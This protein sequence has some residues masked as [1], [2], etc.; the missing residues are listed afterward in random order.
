MGR[1]TGKSG[2]CVGKGQ[3][4][5]HEFCAMGGP[6]QMFRK[7][8]RIDPCNQMFKTGQ[9][10]GIQ[11]GFTADRQPNTVH[12]NCKCFCKA[13]QLCQR[14]ATIAHVVFGMYFQP[15][16]RAGGVQ[17]VAKMLGFIADTDRIGQR[18]VCR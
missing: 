1:H 7:A 8:C 13:A 3:K 10:V 17:Q 5:V 4:V 9:M 14:P 16:D 6:S 2:V 15:P 18:A 11:R 12:R